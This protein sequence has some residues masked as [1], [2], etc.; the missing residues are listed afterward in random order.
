MLLPRVLFKTQFHKPLA[1]HGWQRRFHGASR[2]SLPQRQRSSLANSSI[3][4]AAACSSFGSFS[5][6]NA[7]SHGNRRQHS[8]WGLRS[9]P[10]LRGAMEAACVECRELAQGGFTRPFAVGKPYGLEPFLAILPA[11]SYLAYGVVC[12]YAGKY[13]RPSPLRPRPPAPSP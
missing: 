4:G 9:L 1:A 13:Q 12:P 2:I 11:I 5:L 8:M 7:F 6:K 3:L 10:R